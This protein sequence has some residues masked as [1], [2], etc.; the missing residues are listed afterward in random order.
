MFEEMAV[1]D[2]E[3]KFVKIEMYKETES[4]KCIGTRLQMSNSISSK[5]IEDST[6]LCSWDPYL[7]RYYCS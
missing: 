5:L 2:Y 7:V 1:T 3:S 6:L 4:T